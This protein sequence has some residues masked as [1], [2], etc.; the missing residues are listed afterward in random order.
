MLYGRGKFMARSKGIVLEKTD[1]H[2]SIID[3]KTGQ[4]LPL[5]G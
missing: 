2:Y 5:K 4:K 3:P 1:E